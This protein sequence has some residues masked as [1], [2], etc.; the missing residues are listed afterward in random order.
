MFRI[1]VAT[2]TGVLAFLVLEK[3]LAIDLCYDLVFDSFLQV[4]EMSNPETNPKLREKE[5]NEILLLGGDTSEVTIWDK[6]YSC[7]RSE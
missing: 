6:R 3:V 5:N 7:T 2:L 1:G 4:L